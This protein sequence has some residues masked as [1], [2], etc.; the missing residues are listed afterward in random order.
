MKKYEILGHCNNTLSIILESISKNE[1]DPV[2]INVVYRYE[3]LFDVKCGNPFN[4]SFSHVKITE[5]PVAKWVKEKDSLKFLAYMGTQSRKEG[6]EYFLEKYE[7]KE[8]HYVKLFSPS[9][10]IASTAH[11]GS[12]CYV[13]MG[14]VMAPFSD[15]G[16]LTFVNR[17]V[18]IGHHTKVGK[19]STLNPG[20]NIGGCC[21]IGEGVTIGIG[22]TILDNIIVGNNAVIGAGSV[23]T[24]HVAPNTIVYGVPARFIRSK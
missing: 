24:K 5:C 17:K 14:S 7:I 3:E 4:P 1:N 9:A 2:E 10:D 23:V 8:C 6:F 18:S 21:V 15:I 16:D 19:L 12:G 13:D 22:A 20:C 11:L